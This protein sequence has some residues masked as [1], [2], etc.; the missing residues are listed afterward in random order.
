MQTDGTSAGTHQVATFT[1]TI[2]SMYSANGVLIFI[3]QQS[4]GPQM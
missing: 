2:T 3:T 1:T 4:N